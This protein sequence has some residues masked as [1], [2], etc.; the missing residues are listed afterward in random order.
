[1][2]DAKPTSLNDM[3]K[4][5]LSRRQFA[6]DRALLKTED[7]GEMWNIV[8]ACEDTMLGLVA[9]NLGCVRVKLG[10]LWNGQLHGHDNQS[11]QKLLLIDDLRDLDPNFTDATGD[12]IS[13]S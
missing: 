5:L 10:L 11:R 4:Y 6:I 8:A 7:P 1:M 12:L 3:W 2:A 13:F 9:P